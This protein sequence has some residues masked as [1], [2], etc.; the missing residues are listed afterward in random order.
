MRRLLVYGH[1]P[2]LFRHTPNHSWHDAGRRRE[3]RRTSQ[4][5]GGQYTSPH[6]PA[7]HRISSKSVPTTGELGHDYRRISMMEYIYFNSRDELLR[8][9]ITEIAY[10]ESDGNYC[11]VVTANKLRSPIGMTP[12]TTASPSSY[13]SRA[14]RSSNSRRSSHYPLKR[15]KKPCKSSSD[16]TPKPR[17]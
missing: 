17:N 15:N 10:F 11:N 12:T 8:L 9:R 16:A 6:H 3:N 5:N 2:I 1:G 4:A 7:A 13:L 14:T